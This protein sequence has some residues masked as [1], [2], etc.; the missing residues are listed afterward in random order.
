[1]T[2]GAEAGS[3]PA[4]S[5]LESS[6]VDQASGGDGESPLAESGETL[7]V[8]LAGDRLKIS[9]PLTP[10]WSELWPQ[11]HL[12]LHGQERLWQD[13]I[14]VDIYGGDRPLDLEQLTLLTGV[15][16]ALAME[17]TQVHTQHR[18]TAIAAAS[19]GY[20]VI[21]STPKGKRETQEKIDDSLPD[22]PLYLETTLR[23]GTEL[24]HHGSVV[25]VGDVNPGSTIIADGNILVW[26]R[27]RGIAHAGFKGNLSACIMTLN[28]AATQLRIAHL[29]ARTPEPPSQAYPEVA[30]VLNDS[31]QIAPAWPRQ[32]SRVSKLSNQAPNQ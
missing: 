27:L 10:D 4:P 18:E 1:M 5:P 21:Q 28:M 13:P 6:L 9:L 30:Y 16:S 31:I 19:L 26:G 22:P 11:L 25:I 12:R 2:D 23:S 7:E 20:D 24:R 32:R 14:P 29:V 3:S 17:L 8:V 15:F